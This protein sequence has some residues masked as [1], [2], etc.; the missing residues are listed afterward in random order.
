MIAAGTMKPGGPA[1]VE[2]DRANGRWDS[3]YAGQADSET[4]QDFLDALAKSPKA[5]AFFETLTKQNK[6]AVYSRLNDAKRPETRARRVEKFVG[7][8]ERSEKF[9]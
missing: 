7:M 6:Y 1:A 4:P 8:F 5:Q 3:A 2:Q 9:H